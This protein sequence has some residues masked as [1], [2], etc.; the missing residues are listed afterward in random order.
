VRAA[1]QNFLRVSSVFCFGSL[2]IFCR[3]TQK[4]HLGQGS[5]SDHFRAG[6]FAVIKSD[7]VAILRAT[8]PGYYTIMFKEQVCAILT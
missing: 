4:P 2:V 6:G 5:K 7:V 3:D 8:K 1:P